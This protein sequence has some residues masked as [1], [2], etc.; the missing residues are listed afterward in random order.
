[1][2]CFSDEIGDNKDYVLISVKNGE[3]IRVKI[4]AKTNGSTILCQEIES[5]N[6]GVIYNYT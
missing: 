3:D 1:M 5:Y 4:K 2:S 6:Y